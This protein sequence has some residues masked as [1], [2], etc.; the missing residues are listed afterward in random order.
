MA[1][2]RVRTRRK[3]PAASRRSGHAD[4]TAD[5][6]RMSWGVTCRMSWVVTS[7]CHEG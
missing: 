7:V 2:S 5:E 3:S 1:F 6:K 4:V